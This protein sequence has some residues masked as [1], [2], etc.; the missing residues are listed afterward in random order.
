MQGIEAIIFAT[1]QPKNLGQYI[2]QVNENLPSPRWPAK[3]AHFATAVVHNNNM[4]NY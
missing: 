4:F 3:A 2:F 1:T